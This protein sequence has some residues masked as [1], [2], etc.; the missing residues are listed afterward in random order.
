MTWRYN[1]A[2]NAAANPCNYVEG[3]KT[4]LKTGFYSGQFMILLFTQYHINYHII[5]NNKI[6]NCPE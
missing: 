6:I 3:G 4:G 1:G 5:V 2:R